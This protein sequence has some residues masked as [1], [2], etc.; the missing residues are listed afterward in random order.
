MLFVEASAIDQPSA[1]DNID[2]I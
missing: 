1:I 2:P